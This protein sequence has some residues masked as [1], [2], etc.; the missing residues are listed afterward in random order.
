MDY[1][2]GGDKYGS[3]EWS[4]SHKSFIMKGTERRKIINAVLGWKG[5]I[6]EEEKYI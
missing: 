2:K 3:R 4:N 5:R 6:L 1:S